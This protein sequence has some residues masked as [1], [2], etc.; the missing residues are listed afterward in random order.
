LNKIQ[1]Y[2]LCKNR[3]DFFK[4]TLSSVL[5]Q[6]FK[7]Y[8]LI[9][10][11]NSDDDKIK[12]FI[13]SNNFKLKY[14]QRK[15]LFTAI[16]HYRV[17]IKEASKEFVIFL[18]DDDILETNYLFEVFYKITSDP[19]LVA[20]GCN[21]YYL[22]NDLKLSKKFS[23]INQDITISNLLT[24]LRS[25]MEINGPKH[26]P[27]PSYIYKTSKI[28]NNFISKDEGG[29]YSDFFFLTKLITH[30]KIFWLSEPLMSYRIHSQSDSS[31][32]SILDR[33]NLINNICTK[34]NLHRKNNLIIQ[35][36]FKYLLSFYKKD[37]LKY[38]KRKIIVLKFLF[39]QLTNLFFLKNLFKKLINNFNYL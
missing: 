22:R 1:V 19:D 8:D 28:K 35:Y 9:I 32:E 25:Y 12:N 21:A 11:D 13:K 27:F 6:N 3:L 23:N 31:F 24:L 34:Y 14:I 16:E 7:D 10:S 30:G 38:K 4:K 39:F 26:V 2:I 5:N 18:H 29:K 15:K 37:L 17:L 33:I 20:V 36:K